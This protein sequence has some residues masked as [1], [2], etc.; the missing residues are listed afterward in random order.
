MDGG[1]QHSNDN[2]L[3]NELHLTSSP[4]SVV[5]LGTA[6]AHESAPI[7]AKFNTDVLACSVIRSA[8]KLC[9][10]TNADI[11][12]NVFILSDYTELER[13]EQYNLCVELRR[14]K[15]VGEPNVIIRNGKIVARHALN[16]PTPATPAV[17]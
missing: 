3:A 8:K 4:D 9:S 2:I 11:K 7:L 10:L 15:A 12:A 16:S 13:T 1:N 14:R 6:N 5:R 17:P